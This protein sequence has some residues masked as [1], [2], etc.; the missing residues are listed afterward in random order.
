MDQESLHAALARLHQ[1]LQGSPQLDAES[2]R[3]LDE[4]RADITRSRAATDSD[5]HASR[6]EALAV[7]FEAGYPALAA[8]LRGIADAL[9]R[10]GL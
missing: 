5:A 10:I 7:R 9:G 8:S 1:E 6:L 4:L 3:L 2:R